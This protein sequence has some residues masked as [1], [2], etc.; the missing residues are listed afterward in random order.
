MLDPHLKGFV[1]PVIVKY[2]P[3]LAE[4]N[5]VTLDILSQLIY[6]F[7][8]VRGAKIITR[9]LENEPTYLLTMV[10]LLKTDNIVAASATAT[11]TMA[12]EVDH[13]IT[14]P[15]IDWKTRYVLLLWIGHL[16]LTP[17]DLSTVSNIAND[18]YLEREGLPSKLPLVVIDILHVCRT[19]LEVASNEQSTAAA[20]LVRL[21]LRPDMRQLGLLD[22]QMQQTLV[23]FDASDA[24]LHLLNGELMFLNG[25]ISSANA[26]DIH[27]HLVDIHVM[28]SRIFYQIHSPLSAQLRSSAVAK[29]FAIKIWHK[30]IIHI[31]EHEKLSTNSAYQVSC[32]L[33][34][35]MNA[36]EDVIDFLLRSLADRDTQ[37]RYAA[38]KAL[39]M[40]TTKLEPGLAEEVVMAVLGSMQEDVFRGDN[41]EQNTSAVNAVRWHGLTLTLAHMLFRRSPVPDQL[42]DVLSTLYNALTFEQRSASGNSL[43]TNVRDAANFGLWSMARRYSTKELLEVVM[44]DQPSHLSGSLAVQATACHLIA[45]ACLDPA[46]N[47]RRGSSA[48]LQELIGRHPDTIVKGISL[49]QTVDYHAIGLRERAMVDV[50]LEAATFSEMYRVILVNELFG[51]RGLRAPDS[52]S[53]EFA[54]ASIGQLVNLELPGGI[55]SSTDTIVWLLRNTSTREVELRHGLILSLAAILDIFQKRIQADDESLHSTQVST[56]ASFSRLWTVFGTGVILEAKDLSLPSMKSELTIAAICSLVAAVAATNMCLRRLGWSQPDEDTDKVA[57][58]QILTTCLSVRGTDIVLNLP[59]ACRKLLS[60]MREDEQN[61]LVGI[62]LENLL[63]LGTSPRSFGFMIALGAVYHVLPEDS[64]SAD[65]V[66]SG[67]KRIM[68]TLIQASKASDIETRVVAIRALTLTLPT[69]HEKVTD[70]DPE[71]LVAVEDCLNDYTINER[72]DV[73]S[74]S[75]FQALLAIEQI[76][77]LSQQSNLE[78]PPG[79]LP[80][81]VTVQRLAMERLDKVRLQAAKCLCII[82]GVQLDSST[83][84]Y[85]YMTNIAMHILHMAVTVGEAGERQKHLQSF[86]IGV[87]S[88]AGAGAESLIEPTRQ[89]LH[90]GM[91]SLPA[92][93][94]IKRDVSLPSIEEVGTA[95]LELF[96]TTIKASD[97]RILLPLL[98]TVCFLLDSNILQPLFASSTGTPALKPLTV[99]S[100]TQRAHFKSTSLPKLLSCVHIYLH[101]ADLDEIRNEVLK[102]LVSMLLHPFPRVRKAVAEVLWVVTGVEGLKDVNWMGNMSKDIKA[103]VEALRRR[104]LV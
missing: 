102:K 16:M 2:G 32:R 103:G 42:A 97:D 93:S 3:A 39:G 25:L 57:V 62:W 28:I 67:R 54:A 63:R 74:L 99:L 55:Q 78:L 95:L 45:S 23:A 88:S 9:F 18:E 35:E 50:A 13:M 19:N 30:I 4:E 83:D 27:Q 59:E 12:N 85:S 36:L 60:T 96:S 44:P 73:G 46:G 75:R 87:T 14:K 17:F 47:V 37:V 61:D 29:K 51:W 5:L 48:A 6:V 69:V 77:S 90:D 34:H 66:L 98:D 10:N 81:L 104:L 65:T 72:G 21:V 1:S 56:L 26:N 84:V 70:P 11:V 92:A 15:K 100:L 49:V 101:L 53:R 79:K 82:E 94:G 31:L 41:G 64:P 91:C 89:A 58:T 86:W 38:S 40:I 52:P 80:S 8:K 76:W 20:A 24:G 33:L 43:G 71:L 68:T 22:Y 7:C